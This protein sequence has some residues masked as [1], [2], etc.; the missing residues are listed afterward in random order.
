MT[1]PAG[2]ELR[3]PPAR[4]EL[5][6]LLGAAIGAS[7]MRIARDLCGAEPLRELE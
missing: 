5:Q 2:N 1:F 6:R 7:A 3:R 4:R